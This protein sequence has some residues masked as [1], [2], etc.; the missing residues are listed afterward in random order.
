MTSNA[1]IQA[2]H[3]SDTNEPMADLRHIRK[4]CSE[5]SSRVE[6]RLRTVEQYH[7]S[8]RLDGRPPL[9]DKTYPE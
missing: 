9:R 1:A 5:A 7:H 4:K 6:T 8:P 3:H 2:T